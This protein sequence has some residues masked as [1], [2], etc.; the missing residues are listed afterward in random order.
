MSEMKELKEQFLNEK[1]E[2]AK[3]GK[4]EAIEREN[5]AINREN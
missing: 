4:A 2:E 1:L 3:D 5:Q